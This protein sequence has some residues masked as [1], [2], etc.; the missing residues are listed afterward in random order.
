MRISQETKMHMGGGKAF[1][2]YEKAIIVDGKAT[3]IVRSQRYE[4]RPRVLK[5]DTFH[6]GEAA[7]DWLAAGHDHAA[8]EAWLAERLAARKGADDGEG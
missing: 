1:V 3:G 8:L 5:V 2:M 6:D 4:G 7:F